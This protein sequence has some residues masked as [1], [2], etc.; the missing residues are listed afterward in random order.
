[1]HDI[2]LKG[3]MFFII[4]LLPFPFCVQFNNTK[5]NLFANIANKISWKNV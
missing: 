4:K 5:A 2:R 3:N 1:M